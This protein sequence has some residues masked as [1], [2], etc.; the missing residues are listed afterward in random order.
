MRYKTCAYYEWVECKS[1]KKDAKKVKSQ[2]KRRYAHVLHVPNKTAMLTELIIDKKSQE[3][4]KTA[5]PLFY[6]EKAKYQ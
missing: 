3:I 1:K 4:E 6:C 2:K 5:F